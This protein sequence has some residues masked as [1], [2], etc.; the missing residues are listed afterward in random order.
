MRGLTSHFVYLKSLFRE[1]KVILNQI[2]GFFEFGTINALMGPSGAG[3]TTL[4]NAINGFYPNYLTEET[5]IF[6][7]KFKTIRTCFITQNQKDHI[8]TGLTAKQAVTYASKLKNSDKDFDHKKNVSNIMNELMISNTFETNVENCSGGEQK[9]LV[10]AMEMTSAVKPNLLCIDE[11]T[12]G[13]DSNAAEVVSHLFLYNFYLF[14]Y[15]PNLSGNQMF[16]EINSKSQHLC[17]NIN[18]FAKQ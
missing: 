4:L 5:K 17:H 15:F 7:S 8:L 13:L 12:S 6:L 16:E 2:N 14:N 10:I 9:R 11:P 18:T 3:K 1:Q